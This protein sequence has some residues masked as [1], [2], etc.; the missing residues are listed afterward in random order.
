MPDSQPEPTR[1]IALRHGETDWNA[2][3]RIQG[4]TDIALNARGLEQARLTALA[5]ADEPVAAVYASDLQRAWQTAQAIAALHGLEVIRD[6]ALRERCFGE[7][8]GHS[9]A[10]LQ[11]LYPALCERWRQRDP[12]FAAPG[13]E[14]LREFAA[15][16]QGALLRIAA[17]HAGQLIVVAVHG[18]VLDA[19]YRAATGQELQAP[20]SFELRNAAINRLLYAQGQLT[21]V[22][23]GDTAHLDVA[24]NEPIG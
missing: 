24:E 15:R 14:T 19:F 21:L 18:G 10:A 20:R 13:G 12:E 17:R 6:A 8:E 9:F 5:L 2:A 4:H 7:F 23:W 16:A 22:G 11:P 1:I 3:S